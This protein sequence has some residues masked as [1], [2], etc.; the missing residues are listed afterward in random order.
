V[1]VPLDVCVTVLVLVSEVV[2]VVVL[3]PLDV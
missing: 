2:T 1:L 3:V